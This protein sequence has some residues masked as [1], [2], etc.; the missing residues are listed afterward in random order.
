MEAGPRFDYMLPHT[1][2]RSRNWWDLAK[3]LDTR[4]GPFCP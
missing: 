2:S 3:E 1:S 4:D